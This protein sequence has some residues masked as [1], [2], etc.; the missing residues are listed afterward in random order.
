ML[1]ENTMNVFL[2]NTDYVLDTSVNRC[3]QISHEFTQGTRQLCILM[4][5]KTDLK[6]IPKNDNQKSQTHDL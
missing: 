1:S 3:C 2:L 5:M 6:S 4:L